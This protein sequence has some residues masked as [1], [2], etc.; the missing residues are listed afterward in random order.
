MIGTNW[1]LS[2]YFPKFNGSEMLEF[3]ANMTNQIRVISDEAERLESLTKNN[4]KQ[5]EKV[6]LAFEKLMTQ[7][8]HISSYIA[9]LSSSDTRN[10]EYRK[11]SAEVTEIAS[12][13]HKIATLIKLA[14]K[15]CTEED[16][17]LLCSMESLKEVKFQLTEMRKNSQ[18]TM[19]KELENLASDLGTDGFHSWGRLYNTLA[20]KLTFEMEWPDGRKE[21][22]PI[23]RCRSTMQDT[24]RRIRKTAFVQGNKAWEKVEDVC[25]ACLNAISGIRLKLNKKRGIENFLDVSLDQS[26]I[27]AKTLEAMFQAIDESSDIINRIARAKASALGLEKL[28]WYDCEAPLAIPSVN[29]YSWEECVKLVSSSFSSAYPALAEFFRQAL[30]KQW[31]ESEPRAG[32]SP[33]AYCTSS[34][35]TEQSRVFMSFGGSLHDVSTL[36]HETGHAFHSFIMKGL[37]PLRRKYP[38]TLAET[39]ST[40]AE[41]LLADGIL[42]SPDSSDALKLNILTENINHAIAFLIDIPIRFKFEKAFHEERLNGEVSVSRLKE[43]MVQ[44]MKKQ[45]GDLLAED[46][47]N[48]FFWASKLHFY[49]TGVTFYN[50]PYTFGY[51]LSRGLFENF[52]QEKEKFLPGYEEFLRNSGSNFA[53]I[54]AKQ[55]VGADLECPDFWKSAISSHEDD[56]QKFEE[57]VEKVIGNA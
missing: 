30:D 50:Y 19:S 54:V 21:I 32:K 25:A 23:S 47:V 41:M 16:F 46:G 39:A 38:M 14:L 42:A 51:L 17:S 10:E 24:N 1:D 7:V 36:A 29:R 40:F 52:K 31:I 11:A 57:L 26:R 34:L 53:H 56:L 43:L 18:K 2:S 28:A 33:G 27:S 48:P 5:W 8:S 49:S 22:L 37:R 45:F 6:I 13:Y 20:G 35:L 9:C 15:N 4:L 55:T 12:D 44:A 3:K